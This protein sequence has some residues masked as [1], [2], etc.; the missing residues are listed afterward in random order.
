M[1]NQKVQLEQT[2]LAYYF[3]YPSLLYTMSR[4][5]LVLPVLQLRRLKPP[6][7][8]ALCIKNTCAALKRQRG[9]AQ[10]ETSPKKFYSPAVTFC[11]RKI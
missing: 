4:S 5:K 2:E 6:F 1:R 8:A 9:T 7:P 3:Q 10:G 11:Q